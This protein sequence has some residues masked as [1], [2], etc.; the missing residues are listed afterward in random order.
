MLSLIWWVFELYAKKI[1][2]YSKFLIEAA[3]K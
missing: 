3:E 2:E 1:I